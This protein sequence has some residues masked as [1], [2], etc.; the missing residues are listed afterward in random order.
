MSEGSASPL[1]NLS[2]TPSPPPSPS[3]LNDGS[4]ARTASEPTAKKMKISLVILKSPGRAVKRPAEG[5]QAEP[6]AKRR[7]AHGSEDMAQ[8]SEEEQNIP[9]Q[10]EQEDPY[11]HLRPPFEKFWCEEANPILPAVQEQPEHEGGELYFAYGKDMDETYL[12]RLFSSS[13]LPEPPFVSIAKLSDYSWVIEPR[14]RFPVI[15]PPQA[16][17]NHVYGL[18]YRLSRPALDIMKAK[19][20]KRGLRLEEKEVQLFGKEKGSMPGFWNDPIVSSGSVTVTV[21]VG[22]LDGEEGKMGGSKKKKVMGGLLWGATLGLP[23]S[24]KTEIR[25]Q[26]GTAKG[27]EDTGYW[28]GED[29]EEENEGGNTGGRSSARLRGKE[30]INYR[31]HFGEEG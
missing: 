8:A 26:L 4:A 11:S 17:Q 15:V 24:W 18:V 13:N 29:D 28:G 31:V 20:K 30:K 22:T 1:S 10:Q 9:H 5:K 12:F 27:P 21:M 7:K 23:E 14:N 3:S 25:G 6:L 19:A 2:K 16:E